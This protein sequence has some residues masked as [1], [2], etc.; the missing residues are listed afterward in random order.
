MLA[1]VSRNCWDIKKLR[2]ADG[3]W[4]TVVCVQINIYL[5]MHMPELSFKWNLE[6]HEQSQ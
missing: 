1:S 5:V 2:D 3:S 6:K 4:N